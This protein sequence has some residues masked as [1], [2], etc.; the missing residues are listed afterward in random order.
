MPT[1]P[2]VTYDPPKKPNVAHTEAYA[3]PKTNYIT[4]TN[5]Y[6]PPITSTHK[7]I[8]KK[9]FTMSPVQNLPTPI[10]KTRLNL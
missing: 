4:P 10:Y 2:T 8:P 5:T 6:S 1:K 3:A 7:D 9:G